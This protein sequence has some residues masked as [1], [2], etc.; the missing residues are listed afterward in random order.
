MECASLWK[1]ACD[2]TP[3][4]KPISATNA[5]YNNAVGYNAIMLSGTDAPIA[6]ERRR[7]E[8]FTCT[9]PSD[10]ALQMRMGEPQKGTARKHERV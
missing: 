4:H 2:V 9:K 10:E 1:G 7:H 3:L 5:F 6:P 8:R